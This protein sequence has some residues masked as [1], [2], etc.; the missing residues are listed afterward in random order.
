MK[1]TI[2]ELANQLDL[3]IATISRALDGYPDIS[4]KTRQRVLAAALHLGYTPD[5]AARQLRRRRTD[6]IG[7]ILPA[8]AGKFPQPFFNELIAGLAAG[9]SSRQYDL[10]ISACADDEAAEMQLYQTWAQGH[11]VDGLVVIR[12]RVDDRRIAFLTA[13]E[14]PFVCLEPPANQPDVPGIHVDA[15]QALTSVVRHLARRGLNRQAFLG[16]PS[17]LIIQ[18]VRREAFRAAL[19]A[20]NLPIR[21]SWQMTSDMTS[22]GGYDAAHQLLTMKSAPN[23]L[24]CINDEVALGALHAA[25]DLGIAVGKQLAVVAFDGSQTAVHATPPLT[26]IDQPV[27]ALAYQLMEMLYRRLHGGIG[28]ELQVTLQPVIHL[29]TSSGDTPQEIASPFVIAQDVEATI[30]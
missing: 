18:Q 9:A 13:Q 2:K 24:V 30:R 7:F 15:H 4:E 17:E 19:G 21:S 29:R 1:V 23:C 8:V 26:T 12:T 16:G 25:S 6:T 11:R 14:F 28:L 5:R 27:F 3:S 22:Q 20:A 10:L